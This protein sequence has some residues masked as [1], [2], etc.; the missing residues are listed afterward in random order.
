MSKKSGFAVFLLM[1][2]AVGVVLFGMSYS[3]QQQQELEMVAE[4]TNKKE[5][6]EI[7]EDDSQQMTDYEES[8]GALSVLDYLKYIGSLKEEVSISFYGDIAQEEPWIAA[9][10]E[11]IDEQIAS[12]INSNR[13]AYPTYNSYQLISENK[14]TELAKTNPNVVFFQVTPY[15]DQ[16]K[17]ISLDDSSEYLAMNYAAIKDVL[18]EALVIFVTPNPSSSERGNNNSRTLDYTSY[19][20]E[21][22]ATVEENEWT[23]FDLHKSY[24]KKLET[25]GIALENTLNE[26]GKSLNGEGTSIYSTLFEEMLNQKVDTTSGI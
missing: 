3:K 19:L 9:T 8:R 23:V 24:L 18:P 17:D 14:V 10:E 1:I 13:L 25:D 2:L 21:M 6:V 4:Q 22:V 15:A 5:K 11:Y 16:E 26:T 20:N 12:K 7:Q